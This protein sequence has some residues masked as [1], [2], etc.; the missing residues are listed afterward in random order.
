MHGVLSPLCIHQ[1]DALMPSYT[2]PVCQGELFGV[3]PGLW[4][5]SL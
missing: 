1:E 2:L 4:E 3:A 5:L